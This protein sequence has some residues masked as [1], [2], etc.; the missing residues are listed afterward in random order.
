MKK[1]TKKK[2]NKN[3]VK[4][5]K[6]KIPKKVEL[7]KSIVKVN[8]LSKKKILKKPKIIKVESKI[9]K[10]AKINKT[11]VNSKAKQPKRITSGIKGLDKLIEGG[12]ERNSINLVLGGSGTGKSIFAMQFLM[13]GIRKGENVL[14]ITFEESKKEFFNNMLEMGWNLE[15]LESSGKL[16]FLEHSPQKVKMMLDEGGGSIETV[17]NR[18]QIK[19]MA[20]DSLSSFSLLFDSLSE[21]RHR[22]LSL[23]DII[24]KWNLTSVFTFQKDSVR[25][26]TKPTTQAELQVDS[27]I[28]LYL[29]K[30]KNE[31]TR[32][33]EVLKM[34]GTKHSHSTYPVEIKKGGLH[35]GNRPTNIKL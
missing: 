29:K 6:K 33:I 24:R 7:K 12:I 15:K 3:K 5:E 14:F 23:F 16:T 1:K 31:R 10:V 20:V 17:V 13:E 18:K 22:V 2:V 35:V 9:G 21:R 8:R 26:K 34:R 27:I 32:F 30:I 25:D 28:W 4:K 11:K 19:R